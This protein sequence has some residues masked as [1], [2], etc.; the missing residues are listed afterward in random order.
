M[1]GN[2]EQVLKWK[3]DQKIPQVLGAASFPNAQN[4]SHSTRNAA[5]PGISNLPFNQWAIRAA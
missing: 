1:I 4:D 3:N 2:G 5:H